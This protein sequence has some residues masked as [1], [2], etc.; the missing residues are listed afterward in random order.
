MFNFRGFG[1]DSSING[2]GRLAQFEYVGSLLFERLGDDNT[3]VSPHDFIIEALNTKQEVTPGTQGQLQAC[4]TDR[5]C[6]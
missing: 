2:G 4:P 6:T 5:W 3:I 1:R